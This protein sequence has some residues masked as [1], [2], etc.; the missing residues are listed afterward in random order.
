MKFAY[1]NVVSAET[2]IRPYY[3]GNKLK[4]VIVR[5]GL[6][7]FLISHL[8]ACVTSQP[9]RTGSVPANGYKPS[10]T[11]SDLEKNIH[12]L[13]NRE[14]QKHGL[15]ILAWND[16]LSFIAKK[17]SQDMANRNYFSHN[18]PEGHDFSYRY[19]EVGYSCAVHGQGNIY[20]TGAEYIFLFFLYVRIV[21]VNGV[22]HYDWNSEGKIAETTVQG[23]M[24]SK[25]HRTNILT[26]YWRTEG[27]GVAIAPDGKVYITQNFC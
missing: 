17:H 16:T 23:W 24:R 27:I 18:T 8:V 12:D 11:I 15:S 14:R 7:L 13:I 1:Y 3:G 20:Y 26:P 25:G 10:I 2:G 21:L 9:R 19:G 4:G 22:A 5:S 6:M